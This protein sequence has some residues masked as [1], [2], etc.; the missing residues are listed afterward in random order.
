MCTKRVGKYIL[1]IEATPS[2]WLNFGFS[3][4]CT[5]NISKQI[6]FH[7]RQSLCVLMLLLMLLLVCFGYTHRECTTYKHTLICCRQTTNN[8]Y[9]LFNFHI[10]FLHS[11]SSGSFFVVSKF[12]Q[13][14]FTNHHISRV[15]IHIPT[16]TNLPTTFYVQHTTK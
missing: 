3:P 9:F 2:T 13:K 10:L 14:F 5:R 11:Y 7:S 1:C 8:F 15:Y 16:Y 4:I 6:N 12:S